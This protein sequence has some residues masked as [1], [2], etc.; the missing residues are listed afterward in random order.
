MKTLLKNLLAFT[1]LIGL[2]TPAFGQLQWSS[3]NKTGGLVTANVASGG[4]ATYGGSVNFTVPA[5]TELVFMTRTFVP[6]TLAGASAAQKVNFSMT[7]NGGLYPSSTGRILGMGLLNDP[8][9][10]SSALDDQGYWTDFNTGNPSFE[11]F[12]I[13]GGLTT[14]FQYDSAHKLSASSTK[15]G[16]PTNN[17]TYGMQFQLNMNSSATAIGIGTSGSVYANAGAAMTNGNGGVVEISSSSS[18]GTVLLTTLPTTSFNEFAFMFNNTASTN[19]T[20]TLSGITLVPANPVITTQPYNTG[21]SP[22]GDYSFSVAVSPN[23]GTPLSYQWYQATVSATNALTDGAT[24]N[25]STVSGSTSATLTINDGQVADSSGFFVVI[26]NAYGVVTSSVATLFISATPTVPVINFVSPASATVVA[27]N[28]TNILVNTYAAPTPVV[29]WYDNNNNLLQSSVSTVLSLADLQLGDAGTYTVVS[30]NSAGSVSANFTINVV[31]T[32]SISQQPTNLLL[33]V[34]DPANFSVTASGVPAPTYQWYKNNVLIAGATATNYSIASVALTD[35]GTYSVVVSNAAG[36]VSSAGA[37]L[38]IYSTM[39]GT[40]SSPANNAAGICVDALLKITFNQTPSVGSTGKINIYDASNPTTPV[41]TLDLSGGN[42]QMRSVGG[43][44][45]N[46]YNIL[47]SGN[48]ATIYPHAGVLTLNK[49]YYVTMDPGVIIDANGAYFAGVA[50]STTWQFATKTT[51]PANPTN[52]VVAADGSGNFCTV[53]GAIDSVPAA[54]TTPTIINI[55]NGL[56]TEVNRVNGKNNLTF[57]GQSRHQTVINYANNNNINGS[58]T[59][60]PMF[61]VNQAN[62]IAIENLTLTNSTPLGGS[63]AEALLVNYAKQFIALDCDLDSYQDTL[64]VNQSGD[65]AYIQDSYIQGN[66]DYIWGSGTLYVTNTLLMDLTSQS[67]LTQPRTAQN[68]NGFAFVNCRIL[69]ANSSATNCDLGRDAGASGNTANYPYVQVA[70]INCTMDTNV[71]IP[72]GWILGSG[73]TQGSETANLRFWEYQSVDTNGNLVPTASRV[74]WSL[75]LDGNTATNQVQNVTNWFY[76]WLPQLAPDILTNPAGLSVAGGQS[77]TFTVSAVG[78]PAPS[79]QWLD[80]GTNIPAATSATYTIPAAYAGNAGSY[81]VI[82]SNAAGTVTSSSVTLTVGNTAPT[83]ALVSDQTVNVGVTVNI[84]DAATDPDV[85]PQTLTY[86]LLA[87]PAGA[88]LDSGSGAFSW[89]PTVSAANTANPVMVV[90]TDNGTPNL[91]AT[92]SFNII[93]NPLTLPTVSTVS[94]ADGQFSLTVNGQVG[95][96]YAVQVSTNLTDGN[97][98]TLFTTNSPPSPFT[99]TDSSAGLVPAQF[100]R[101]VVGPPL[102]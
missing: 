70:Y 95:P 6:L 25:G 30:S 73:T 34:G 5:S 41:D 89:R 8:G 77:A 81:S 65:Q 98:T 85:P 33:N 39:S 40:P 10:P 67:H 18:S 58:S 24:G 49:T 36:P 60:R 29:Y 55:H 90:A 28:G 87:A 57:I 16:Y 82:V 68:T 91:S 20:V 99:F 63:Q 2:A 66:T 54:N 100:Y 61:G 11:L 4:D 83:P 17:I 15:T 96:D 47:I 46:T 48:T 43:I 26:T 64:L 27:G 53:Q 14:F 51:G 56:Y 59:T 62:G 88:T 94:Y 74:P 19:V 92:N 45:L 12:Y 69:G 79:Y 50:N 3:Y 22:G 7:A 93:V 9:T 1:M 35:I 84:T 101:I 38:A 80:N 21:G 13:P 76:G 31:V 42:L 75:E 102:P 23:S 32:P 52:L 86:A 71:I 44:L 37:V 78:I 72:A 97:W